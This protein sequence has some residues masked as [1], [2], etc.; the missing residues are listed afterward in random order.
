MNPKTLLIPA[1][2]TAAG[3]ASFA[4]FGAYSQAQDG[5]ASQAVEGAGNQAPAPGSEAAGGE[6]AQQADDGFANDVDRLSYAI[7]L[8]IGG[9]FRAQEIEINPELIAEAIATSYAG[10]ESRLPEER[11][12][13]VVQNFQRQMQMKQMEQQ[14]QMQ[15]E[16]AA[17]NAQAAEAFFAENKDKEGVQQTE[18]GLQYQITEEGDGDKPAAGDTVT[19]HYKGTLLNG[20]VFDSSYERGEPVSF[21]LAGVI[22][23]FAEGLQLMNVGSKG[24]LFIPG[25]LAYGEQGGPGGP[26]ATLIFEVELLGVEKAQ[27]PAD[28]AALGD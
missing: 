18:S 22:S 3:F 19:V 13:A 27:E 17:A 2:L 14:M 25:N 23:G 11:A 24:K 15:Q 10:Q 7:G 8:D 6:A 20:E 16:Q 4:L 9:S 1:C 12:V 26:N 21:P 28:P 5:D